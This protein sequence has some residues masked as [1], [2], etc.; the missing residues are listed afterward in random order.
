MEKKIRIAHIV[1]KWVGGGVEAV[2]MNYYKNIDRK[3]IQF[4]FICDNDSTNIPYNEIEKLGGNVILIPSY[5]KI[6]KY[7]KELKKIFKEKKYKIIHSHINTL[8]IFPL[9]A[10]KKSGIPIRI[11]HSH[12]T[13]N[14]KELKRHIMKIILKPFS[15]IFATDYFSCTKDA[16]IFLFGKNTYKKNKIFVL[17][18]AIDLNKYKYDLDL[19]KNKRK[20]L[21][22]NKKTIVV[23]A[24]GRFM[25]QK[26]Y[27]FLID[28]YNKFHND[29]K[30]S[31]LILVGQGPLM[32]DIKAKITKLNLQDSIVVLGQRDDVSELY[33]AF[34]LFVLP[35]L[36]EGLGMV[37]VEAQATGLPCIASTEV[38]LDV[39]MTDNIRF[40]D[41]KED[42][43]YWSEEMKKLYKVIKRE[44][45]SNYIK[46]HGYD[47]KFESKK[48]EQKYLELLKKI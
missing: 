47:I 45:C 10:A 14:K 27:D 34:D 44:D 40:I 9:F 1:G 38:P 29:I 22:I 26:N 12:S 11:A 35:S 4:D 7:Q 30:D 42:V 21:N 28:I 23:G 25:K 24:V 43:N 46:K 39:K 5:T 8:S 6:L 15:K 13:S 18:N 16:G 17:N 31:K 20:E 36:Y 3:K 41:L 37:F 48:L 2:L 19:R 33:Q 32:N